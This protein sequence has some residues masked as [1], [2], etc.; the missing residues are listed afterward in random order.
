M[1]VQMSNAISECVDAGGV[2]VAERVAEIGRRIDRLAPDLAA[3][4]AP[5]YHGSEFGAPCTPT[6]LSGAA[7][8]AVIGGF[9]SALS[10]A[11]VPESIEIP[12]PCLELSR[13][14]VRRGYP[15][16]LLLRQY[17]RGHAELSGIL[18]ATLGDE[19]GLE[20]EELAQARALGQAIL[21]AYDDQL[22]A[23]VHDEFVAEEVRWA[24]SPAGM[25]AKTIEE[26][27]AGECPDTGRASK[28]LGYEL[29][30]YHLGVIAFGDRDGDRIDE[31]SLD[32]AIEALAVAAGAE[33]MVTLSAGRSVTFGWLG[34]ASDPDLSSTSIEVAVPDDVSL[35]VGGPCPGLEGFSRAHEDAQATRRLAKVRADAKGRVLVWSEVASLGLLMADEGAARRFVAEQ[36]GPLNADA[37]AA[38]RLRGTL[39]VLFRENDSLTRTAEAMGVHSNTVAYRLRQAEELLGRSVRE[40]RFE[41][42][43]ALKVR[44]HLEPTA[45]A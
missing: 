8:E 36:L 45:E 20:G 44:V 32:A 27:L 5:R 16:E 26:V 18:E 15:L 19:S 14:F 9:G 11:G 24:Q 39:N 38:E 1:N 29:D 6:T 28:A 33:S 23:A 4:V 41:L 7:V 17:R 43:A 30:Q 22:T 37:P 25:R 31:A 2:V 13:S 35:V 3:R 40:G 21:F 12:E 42:E 34:F 10:E